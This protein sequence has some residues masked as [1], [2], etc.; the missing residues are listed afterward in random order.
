[1]LSN[2]VYK[3]VHIPTGKYY[4]GVHKRQKGE[5]ENY[6]LGSGDHITLAVNKH[7]RENFIRETL[8]ETDEVHGNELCYFIE[9]HLVTKKEV[10]DNMC[11]NKTLGGN[12]PPDVTGTKRSQSTKD[13]ISVVQLKSWASGRKQRTQS[14]E[15]RLGRSTNNPKK[16]G[17]KESA[18]SR[19]NKSI[20]AKRRWA[21]I[22]REP[23]VPKFN[24]RNS[25]KQHS[26]ETKNLMRQKA[27]ERW[28]NRKQE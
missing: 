23:R 16:K 10:L 1:M 18:Q 9:S 25:G 13:M 6:Y 28:A 19:L 7:G 5:S 17:T 24:P 27:L 2:I 11:Y 26:D 4:I 20:A 14:V 22:V 12:K 8:F 15:E 3:T 21:H